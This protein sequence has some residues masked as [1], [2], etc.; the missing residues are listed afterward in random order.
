[1]LL[2]PR[3]VVQGQPNLAARGA[4]RGY[5]WSVQLLVD[6]RGPDSYVPNSHFPLI[7]MLLKLPGRPVTA[8]CSNHGDTRLER[9]DVEDLLDYRM[10]KDRDYALSHLHQA[11]PAQS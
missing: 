4:P 11:G 10:R 1:M 9:G 7:A 8:S 6:L 3:G 5:G 2:R